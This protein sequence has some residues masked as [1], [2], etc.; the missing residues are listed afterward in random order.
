METDMKIPGP[1]HPIAIEPAPAR[2]RASFQGHVI[3][4][5]DDAM[6]LREAAYPP[7]VYFP[8]TDVST[9][10]LTPTERSTHCPYKGVAA[11][12][13][14]FMDGVFAENAVWTYEEPYPA[15]AQIAG[16][17][18]FYA[19]R[20]DVYEVDDAAVNPRHVDRAAIDE[21]VLHTDSGSGSSQREHWE[22]NVSQPPP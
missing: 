6:V 7:V 19:D 13:T 11:Y 5:T 9:E 8:K 20:V 21:A 18:A 2:W 3:A 4:D 1:D 15:M 17:V 22:P 10:F 16:R 14:L 12:Y